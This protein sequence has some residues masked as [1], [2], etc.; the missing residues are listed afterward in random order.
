MVLN[1]IYEAEDALFEK[2]NLTDITDHSESLVQVLMGY[3]KTLFPR[4]DQVEQTR[5]KAAQ[6]AASMALL[7]RRSRLVEDALIGEINKAKAEER[8]LSI[9]QSLDKIIDKAVEK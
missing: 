5:L 1:T 6:A 3:I 8:S 9:Q 4:N 7:A 2:I